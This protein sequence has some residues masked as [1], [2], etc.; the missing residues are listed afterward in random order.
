[1]N[2]QQ[3]GGEQALAPKRRPLDVGTLL[4]LQSA[5]S[6]MRVPVPWKV[7]LVGGHSPQGGSMTAE[8]ASEFADARV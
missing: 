7:T 3:T 5:A 2:T 4:P 6:G 8:A 1:M